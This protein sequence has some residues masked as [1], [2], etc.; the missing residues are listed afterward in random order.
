MRFLLLIMSFLPIPGCK[1][2][3]LKDHP[4]DPVKV[5]QLLNAESP[6]L[7]VNIWNISI[8]VTIIT[9]IIVMIFLMSWYSA[10]K[11]TSQAEKPQD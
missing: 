11:T 7:K 3:T 5:N 8:I 4:L 1:T 6:V 9:A 10:K 2:I